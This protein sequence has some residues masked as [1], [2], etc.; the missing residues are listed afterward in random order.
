MR[1]Q[2]LYIGWLVGLLL[3]SP[4]FV[5]AQDEP[6]V[7]ASGFCGDG[8][9]YENVTWT[10]YSNDSLAVIGTGA[11][12]TNSINFSG[13]AGQ[14]L[15]EKV[16]KAYF[17]DGLT[18]IGRYALSYL[19]NLA[20]IT[21]DPANEYYD[22]R[23]NCNCLIETKTKTLLFTSLNCFIPNGVEII[24]DYAISD[25]YGIESIRIP[26]SVK[27]MG[28][29]APGVDGPPICA[30]SLKDLYLEWET[31][32]ELPVWV[33]PTYTETKIPTSVANNLTL[34]VPCGTKEMYENAKPWNT[35]KA[36]EEYGCCVI[37]EGDCSDAGDGS[38]TWAF[39]ECG[40]L[41][42]RGAGNMKKYESPNSRPWAQYTNKIDSIVIEEGIT[43]IGTNAFY[44]CIKVPF[45][46]IPKS[47]NHISTDAFA[48][49]YFDDIYVHWE[50]TEIPNFPAGMP[51][52]AYSS[53]NTPTLHVPCDSEEAF[54]AAEGWKDYTIVTD[55]DE[56]YTVSA[57]VND[58]TMGEVT[59]EIQE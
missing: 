7:V 45:I 10:I 17:S 44:G 2:L 46:D 3:G 15:P 47:V 51:T 53:T 50:G 57:E 52:E 23:D 37:A 9:N 58:G 6:T 16:K 12:G 20:Y 32:E 40:T 21:V 43:R 42:I 14:F 13:Y 31:K 27:Q 56:T 19:H 5:C 28:E 36:I 8:D 48:M 1:K 11:M 49:C 38:V 26:R 29:E 33:H 18:Y 54:R 30:L 24:R 22:S 55:Y 35:C 39:D 34:H 25:A 4:L 41:W 59:I